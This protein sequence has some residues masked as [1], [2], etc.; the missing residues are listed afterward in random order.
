MQQGSLSKDDPPQESSIQVSHAQT[1]TGF[2]RKKG[3][4]PIEI[5]A[6]I[7]MKKNQKAIKLH[8]P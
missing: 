7:K 5:Q 1:K 8:K 2:R 4:N 6:D 3:E